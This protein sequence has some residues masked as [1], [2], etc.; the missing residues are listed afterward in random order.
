M[1]LDTEG[2][3]FILVGAQSFLKSLR[4]LRGGEVWAE[5]EIVILELGEQE[6]HSE[7]VVVDLENIALI[8]HMFSL[9]GIYLFI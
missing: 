2:V 6:A 9:A 3:S 5:D 8:L 4:Q 1:F 7:S